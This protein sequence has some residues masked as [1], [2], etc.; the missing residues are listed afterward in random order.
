M[1]DE[2]KL[3]EDLLHNDGIRFELKLH[4]FTPEGVGSFLQEFI[5]NMK[6]GFIN[7]INAQPK[8]SGVTEIECNKDCANCWKTKLVTQRWI[9]VTESLPTESDGT[10]LVCHANISPYNLTEHYVNAKHDQRVVIG[11]YSQHSGRW[12]G[13][14]GG[15]LNDVTHWMPLPKPPKAGDGA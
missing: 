15:F 10:V 13:E 6:Q 3:I 9:P 11:H 12:Y 5:D 2:K 1:I 8:V 14:M 4:D 7:L